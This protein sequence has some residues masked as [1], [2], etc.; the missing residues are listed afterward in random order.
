MEEGWV[1]YEWETQVLCAFPGV[2][3]GQTGTVCPRAWDGPADIQAALTALQSWPQMV[4]G[5]SQPET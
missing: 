3:C 5:A 1:G 4:K 2:V